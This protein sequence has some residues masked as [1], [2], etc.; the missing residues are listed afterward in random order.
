MSDKICIFAGTT[1]GRRLAELLKDA[2]ELTVCVATEY[3]AAVLEGIDG[4]N[5]HEGRMDEAAMAAFFAEQGFDRVIDATHPYAD[6]V[7]GNIA[8]AAAAAGIPLLRILREEDT[9]VSG[10]VYVSSV[11]EAKEYLSHRDGNILLTTGT[12]ELPDYEGLDMSRVWARV[13]PFA[14]SLDAC[15]KA[16]IPAAHVIA[17]QGPFTEEMDLAQLKM[18]NAK[19]IV[20]KA[21]GSAGGFE[22]KIRAASACGAVP[23]IIGRPPQ[24]AGMSFD[25]AVDELGKTYDLPKRRI[26]LIGIGPGDPAMLTDEARSALEGCDAMIGA[27]SVIGVLGTN[28]PCY[29]DYAPEKVRQVLESHPSIRNAA[30]VFRG[31]TGFFSGAAKIMKEFENEDITVIPG[32]SSLAALSA[33]LGVSWDDAAF[34]SLH[35]REANFVS[36]V[37]R[38]RK[39]FI[40]TGGENTP[41]SVCRRLEEYGFGALDAAV[42][43]KV[44]Y[45]DGRI[46]RGSVAELA[47]G[48]YDPL[49]LVYVENP[50]AAGRIPFGID[51]GEFIRGDVPMTKSEVRAISMAK[52]AL[53]TDSVVWDVGA[54]TGSVSVECA[55]AAYEGRVY[56]VEKNRDAVELIKSNKLKFRADN[57]TVTE[58]SAPEALKALPAP[59]HVFIGG[60]GGSLLAILEL[61]LEKSPEARIVINTVT[62]ESQAE[63]FACAEEFGFDEFEAVSVNVSRSK[64]AGAYHMMTAQNPVTVFSMQRG[65]LHG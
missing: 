17:A 18:I 3:G 43:E 6:L 48:T 52:L 53:D 39:L 46:V 36:A 49:S 59:T 64:K 10:A 50:E 38:N 34:I 31:D 27:A 20:T 47:G 12:K 44:S 23:V 14:A 29:R 56:A 19:Y 2:A 41:A 45:P 63:V 55:L 35:G 28:K 24:T 22:E 15:E 5:I 65:H 16:G 21:S 58:G 51:D 25:E 26:T 30:V 54:G 9:G 11:K 32:V 8:A 4:I 61:L 62:L 57:I 42:G 40:L 7:T 1:E 37:S 60:S 13:L 33:R